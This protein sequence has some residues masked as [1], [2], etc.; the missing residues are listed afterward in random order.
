MGAETI[1]QLRTLA[2]LPGDGRDPGAYEKKGQGP[3]QK[4][5]AS[6][7]R[8][9]SRP[10]SLWGRRAQVGSAL[11][12]PG[13]PSGPSCARVARA[14]AS[15]PRRLEAG[16]RVPGGWR[17]GRILPAA[18]EPSGLEGGARE[19]WRK[20]KA[21]GGRPPCPPRP[22]K[23]VFES[24]VVDVLNRFL[25]DYV[26][27]LDTSQLTLG[28]WGGNETAA[29]PRSRLRPCPLLPEPV[30]PFSG[31]RAPCLPGVATCRRPPR[32]QIT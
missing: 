13:P 19:G 2:P 32:G 4:G 18:G 24:V 5:S 23:M 8:P 15:A 7:R 21:R 29:A 27:N 3:A 20:K 14:A 31:P 30:S 12:A 16:L 17:Y 1:Q 6:D 26:V 22:K 25:G 9:R 28:I 11:R 10:G